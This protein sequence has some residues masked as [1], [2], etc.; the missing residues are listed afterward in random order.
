MI[1]GL[2]SSWAAALGALALLGALTAPAAES[3]DDLKQKL[4]KD[5]DFRGRTQAA[6]ALGS[7]DSGRAVEPLCLGLKDSNDTVRAAVAAAFG[8][9]Q[10]GGLDCM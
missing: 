7:T 3:I 2:Q 1:R 8:K 9:L 5:D 6:L 10:K 4:L